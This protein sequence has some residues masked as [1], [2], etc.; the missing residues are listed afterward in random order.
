MKYIIITGGVISGLGKGITASSIGLLFK[1]NGIHVTAIKI[2]PYLNID[3]GT[4]SPFE[5]GE[6]YVLADGTE[7]DLDLGNYERFLGIKLSGLNT[8]TTGKIYHNVL[9]KERKGE[10][11]GKTVQIVPHVTNE[12]KRCIIEASHTKIV[13]RKGILNTP[14]LCI[15]EI[16]GTVGDMEISPFIEAVRQMK[17]TDGLDMYFVHVGLVINNGSSGQNMELKTKPLQQSII[18]YRS[19][20]LVPNMLVVRSPIDLTQSPEILEKISTYCQVPIKNIISNHTTP[21]IYF[22]PHNFSCQNMVTKINAKLGIPLQTHETLQYTRILDYFGNIKSFPTLKL[23]IIAKYIAQ[24]AYLSLLRAIEHAQFHLCV[25]VE[26]TWIN[27]EQVLEENVGEICAGFDGFIVPGGFGSRGILGK[28][29]VITYCRI[30]NIPILGIC[31]GMQAMVVD[32]YNM[33]HHGKSSEWELVGFEDAENVVD[34]QPNKNDMYGGNMRLGVFPIQLVEGTRI[35]EIYGNNHIEE[36][37][38][39][40][41][42]VTHKECHLDILQKNGMVIS[43]MCEDLIETVELSGHLFYIGCQYHPEYNTCHIHPN[44]LF[45]GLLNAMQ[46]YKNH[47][48]P[49]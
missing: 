38:R 2:D 6:C 21:N 37:H 47:V 23:A 7:A 28:L 40:R 29:I 44:P 41:Y 22:V 10:Y 46:T 15:V 4:M 49:V 27:A 3:A 9:T 32:I 11:L 1:N 5:H 13:D 48:L 34:I 42:N 36:R 16:G 19:L 31:L 25:H 30:H 43:G 8:I 18:Q 45:I 39:H 20:G 12:I 14:E 24:D 17:Y 33:T 26:I 35:F